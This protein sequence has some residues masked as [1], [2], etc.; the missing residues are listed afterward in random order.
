MTASGIKLLEAFFASFYS[1]FLKRFKKLS[2]SHTFF[3]FNSF[4]KDGKRNSLTDFISNQLKMKKLYSFFAFSMVI[5]SAVATPNLKEINFRDQASTTELMRMNLYDYNADGST[6]RIDGT[7][8]QYGEEYSDD[9]DGND[10]RKMINPGINVC[11][12]RNNVNL[13]VERRQPIVSTDTIYFNIWGLQRKAYQMRFIG[14]NLNHPGLTAF[15]EDNYLHSS[16]PVSLNDT[17]NVKIEI[18]ADPA[19]SLQTRFRLV[20][21]TVHPIMQLTA[22]NA[23]QQNQQIFLNW[24]TENNESIKK[25]WIQKSNDGSDFSDVGVINTENSFSNKYEWVD[26]FPSIGLNYYRIKSLQIDGTIDYSETIKTKGLI[27]EAQIIGF[28]PNPATSNNMNLDLS[29]QP[30]GKYR[31]Q[32]FNSSG[33]MVMDQSFNFTGGNGVQKLSSNLSLKAGIYHLQIL[34]PTGDKQVLEVVF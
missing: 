20:F 32:L 1:S 26:R 4:I 16:T 2:S 6:F 12:L 24:K 27:K 10:G 34:K 22:L 14:V 30:A 25:Y 18:N 17:T 7:V 5:L 23:G 29:N 28:F 15:L 11:L 19:S 8:T 33:Q 9:I 13:V 3:R 21:K 31:V